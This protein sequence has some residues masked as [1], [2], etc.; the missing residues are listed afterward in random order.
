MKKIYI[1]ENDNVILDYCVSP[2]KGKSA[3]VY[4]NVYAAKASFYALQTEKAE[5]PGW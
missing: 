5:F 2:L 1:I 4:V 3:L